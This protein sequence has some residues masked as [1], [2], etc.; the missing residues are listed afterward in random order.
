MICKRIEKAV[1]CYG[2]AANFLNPSF[3][4]RRFLINAKYANILHDFLQT[5]LTENGLVQ[6]E[7]YKNKTGSFEVLFSRNYDSCNTFWRAS[8][9]FYPELSNLALKLNNL[10]SSTGQLERVFSKWAYVHSLKRNRLR[11]DRSAQLVALYYELQLKD[12]RS[13]MLQLDNEDAD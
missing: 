13:I 4:G 6:L 12:N 10:C 7:H 1:N 11:E 2:L 5:T 3:Q 8:R 9:Y